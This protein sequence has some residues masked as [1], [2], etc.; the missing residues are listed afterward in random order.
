[1]VYKTKFDKQR[2]FMPVTPGLAIDMAVAMDSGVVFDTGVLGDYN[3]IEDPSSIRCRVNDAFE[4]I[5]HQRNLLRSAKS[6]A[7]AEVS[8]TTPVNPA[9]GE[10]E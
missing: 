7:P 3:D 6:S 2:D 5:E 10:G 8:Q 1:M 9:K 4:A